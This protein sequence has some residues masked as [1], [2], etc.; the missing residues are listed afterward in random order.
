MT[1]EMLFTIIPQKGNIMQNEPMGAPDQNNDG[2][3]DANPGQGNKP[4]QNNP[5]QGSPGQG[6]P[7]QNPG[8]TPGSAKPS[9]DR[10]G[11]DTS[12]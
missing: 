4:G 3:K 1:I 11:Q 2:R 10:P 6:K 12:R 7:A 8:A 9:Q 5:G